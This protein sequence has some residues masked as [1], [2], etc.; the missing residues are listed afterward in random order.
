MVASATAPKL[1]G[2]RSSRRGDCMRLSHCRKI[3]HLDAMNLKT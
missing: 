1:D 3:A 2:F